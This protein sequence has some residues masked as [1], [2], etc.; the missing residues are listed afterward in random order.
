M[1]RIGLTRLLPMWFMLAVI[2]PAC[3]GP[4]TPSNPTDRPASPA[5][6]TPAPP[7]PAG[8]LTLVSASPAPGSDVVVSS[9]SGG[10][11][12][13]MT[14]AIRLE[15][16]IPDAVLEVQLLDAAGQACASGVADTQA[17][18]AGESVTAV[19]NVKLTCA[20]PMATE[21]VKATLLTVSGATGDAQRTEYLVASF[22]ERYTFRAPGAPPPAPPAPPPA[23][24]APVPPPPAPPPPPPPPQ[25]SG[26]AFLG[27][28]PPPGGETSVTESVGSLRSAT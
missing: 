28:D 9:P 5:A 8:T 10:L 20:V 12:V 3:S 18:A 24:P 27:S 23:P 26:I 2:A 11:S 21:T 16:A 19:A 7:A 25:S 17:V 14:F 6:P 22:P 13:A 4:T 15:A 1:R